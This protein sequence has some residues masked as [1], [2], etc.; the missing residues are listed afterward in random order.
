[1]YRDDFLKE[2]EQLL[3]AIKD[4]EHEDAKSDIADLLE[5]IYNDGYSTGSELAWQYAYDAYN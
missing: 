5:I 2:A 4:K 1:M 3:K